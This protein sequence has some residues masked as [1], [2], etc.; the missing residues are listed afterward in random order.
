[1][2]SN[3]FNNSVIGVTYR[4]PSNDRNNYQDHLEK[5]LT[6]LQ[7]INKTYYI[8]GDININ[9]A[10]DT[11]KEYSNMINSLGGD[12]LIT[13][14]TRI[15][16]NT[17]P[18]LLDHIY[19]N[20]YINLLTPYILVNDISDH[21]PTLLKIKHGNSTKFQARPMRYR[22]IKYI[23][24][25]NFSEDL[26]NQMNCHT[27][28]INSIENPNEAINTLITIYQ[29]LISKYAPYKKLSRRTQKISSKPWLTSGIMK[30]IQTKNKLYV[31][32]CKNKDNLN[33]F[34]KYKSM[35][36]CLPMS[37]RKLSNYFITKNL[38]LKKT[39]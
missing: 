27:E 10:S 15:A 20:N 30:S 29:D 33:I 26:K 2:K 32:F 38:M 28:I 39:I 5:N 17:T 31:K 25:Q 11:V 34:N 12:I 16:Y 36:I 4:H 1:M 23:N 35:L 8:C 14:P 19:S 37:K 18:S 6:S 7:H 3:E 24:M 13:K 9:L 22:N 21:A